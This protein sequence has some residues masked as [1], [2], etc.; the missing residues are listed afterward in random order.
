MKYRDYKIGF[1]FEMPE[2]FNEVREASFE[3]FDV[4]EGT[5]K[6][7]IVLDDE[8]EI[9]RSLSF[10]CDET[11]VK[12]KE[13]F[14]QAVQNSIDDLEYAGMKRVMNDTLTTPSGREIERYIM[15]DVDQEEDIGLLIYFTK[16]KD[17]LV[18]STTYVTEF[19]DVY[20]TELFEIFDSI[21]EI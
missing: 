12:S 10:T 17:R 18:V 9:V 11:P 1:T 4:A 21:Q 8:G 13:E 16:I 2:H 20:E 7:F 15:C 14:L 19:F 3:V 6:H 5:L